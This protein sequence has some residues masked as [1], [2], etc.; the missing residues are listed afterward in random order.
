MYVGPGLALAPHANVATTIV[1][2]LAEDFSWRIW[3]RGK[4]WMPWRSSAVAVIPS[5]TLHHLVSTGPMAF[6]YLDPLGDGRVPIGPDQLEQGRCRL[7]Q[8]APVIR[9]AAAFAAFGLA[10]TPPR[11]ARIAQVVLEIERRP[12]AFHRLQDAAALACLSPSRFRVRFA[13]EVGLPFR[14]YRL[15][16]RMAAVMRGVA[17]GDNLTESAHRAGFSSSAHLS[18]AF[19]QMFG[20]AARDILALDVAIEVSD[21]AAPWRESVDHTGTPVVPQAGDRGPARL[22]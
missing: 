9:L 5:E 19:K 14:R 18:F 10:G 12:D 11:D 20:L 6:L 21:E 13:Q 7:M 17:A 1:V 8:Q 15:W 3:R 22:A 16:R 4:G 2:S